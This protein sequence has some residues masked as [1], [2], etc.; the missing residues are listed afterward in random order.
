M[1]LPQIEYYEK[2]NP[3]WYSMSCSLQREECANRLTEILVGDSWAV[4]VNGNVLFN[5][6]EEKSLRDT[7]IDKLVRDKVTSNPFCM[8]ND[9]MNKTRNGRINIYMGGHIPWFVVCW[10]NHDIKIM[11][12]EYYKSAKYMQSSKTDL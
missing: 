8:L 11:I 12:I 7:I 4:D 2:R 1:A 6:Y 10:Y 5:L 3:S 9:V